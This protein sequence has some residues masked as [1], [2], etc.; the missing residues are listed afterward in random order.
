[1][2]G[3]ESEVI[4]MTSEAQKRANIKYRSKTYKMLNIKLRLT[5][6]SEIIESM[7]NAQAL[8][9]SYRD[10]LCALYEAYKAQQDKQ[11]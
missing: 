11:G 6:D 9:I 7:E 5:E 8:G 3:G 1:M 4:N 2:K 10:W